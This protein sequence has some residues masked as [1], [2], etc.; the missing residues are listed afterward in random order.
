[1]G[2]PEGDAGGGGRDGDERV[3]RRVLP[4]DGGDGFA[5]HVL[6]GSQR[7]VG[8]RPGVGRSEQLP[9]GVVEGFEATLV[10]TTVGHVPEYD[11]RGLLAPAANR[12]TPDLDVADRAV[13]WEDADLRPVG[14]L[15]PVEDL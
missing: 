7:D 10:A 6:E 8:D 9:R 3:R 4:P 13:P 1:V 2:R 5:Q 11:L 15:A 12:P 14:G